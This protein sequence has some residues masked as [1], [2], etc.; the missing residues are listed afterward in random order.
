MNC[1]MWTRIALALLLVWALALPALAEGDFSALSFDEL[2]EIKRGLEE[3]LLTRPE[4]EGRALSEGEYIAG[5]DIPAGT[6][7]LALNPVD[8][9]RDYVD[10]YVYETQGMYA[11][12]VDRL[13]LG[14]MPLKQGRL[15]AGASATVDLYE[16]YCLVAYRNGISIRQE[17]K[18]ADPDEDYEA[19]EGTLVPV[20]VY[21][22]GEEIPAGTY[23][24]HFAGKATA[25]YRVYATMEDAQNDFSDE[26]V[27]LMVSGVNPSGTVYLKE[28]QVVRV[29][30]NDVIMKKSEGLVFD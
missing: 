27:M 20:G 11:Y 29:E 25:R 7:S 9:E 10:Y 17:G 30:Y 2:L 22:V 16:G 15:K 6:Y 8:A 5:K 1:K 18:L 23:T 14:D 26:E 12:D 13:W 24:V 19:P 28:G 21:T 4:Y 3:E